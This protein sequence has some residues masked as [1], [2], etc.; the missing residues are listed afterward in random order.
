MYNQLIFFAFFQ[1]LF[2]IAALLLSSKYRS[3][4]NGY[5]IVLIVALFLGLSGKVLYIS[6]IFGRNPKLILIS[7]IATVLFGCTSFLFLRSSLFRTSFERKE[8][9]HYLPATGYLIL[10]FSYFVLT[11]MEVMRERIQSG[12]LTRVIYLFHAFA[13]MVNVTYW[14]KSIQV[15]RSFQNRLADEVSYGVQTKFFFNFLLLIGGCLLLW[16]TVYL[17]NML[18]VK[19]I[20]ETNFRL[21]IWL[22]LA[23]VVLFLAFYGLVHPEVFQ[24]L[25]KIMDKKYV[26]SKFS[27]E[28]LE[29]LKT[30]LEQLMVDKKPYLNNKL[31]KS[32][33][34]ELLGISNPEMARL[35]NEKIG[36]NFFEFVNFYRIKEFIQLAQSDLNKEL[37]FFG[38][39]QEAGFNSKSTFNKSFKKLMGVSPSQYLKNK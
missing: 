6:E 18:G 39:A 35:L 36:M 7:E 10:I 27:S 34:A 4:I 11:P 15:Y 8:L 30:D 1:C 14:V 3:K 38:L 20:V 28:D 2:L 26:Q 13:L 23:F 24:V 33:L 31:L 21:S 17:L 16:V 25:P 5:I 32:E 22:A 37:T 19:G 9:Y 29:R 12:E